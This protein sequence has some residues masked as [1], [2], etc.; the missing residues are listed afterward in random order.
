[1]YLPMWLTMSDSRNYQHPFYPAIRVNHI[2]DSRFS[3]CVTA[4]VTKLRN[5]VSVSQLRTLNL[6]VTRKTDL[7]YVLKNIYLK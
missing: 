2:N 1:M 6:I 5:C 4:G 3:V 7:I